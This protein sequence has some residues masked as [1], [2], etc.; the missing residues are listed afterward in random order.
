[1]DDQ[2]AIREWLKQVPYRVLAAENGR[3]NNERRRNPSGGRP[4]VL[5]PSKKCGE[6][7]GARDLIRHSAHLYRIKKKQ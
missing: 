1:M 5:R 7:M 6:Q 3:R 2:D 4:K